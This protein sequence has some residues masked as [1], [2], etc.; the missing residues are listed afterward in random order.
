MGID[1]SSKLIFGWEIKYIKVVK[2]LRDLNIGSC[3][4]DKYQCFCGKCCWDMSKLPEG[5]HIIKSSPY[6][7]SNPEYC[8]YHL[9]LI[10]D[11]YTSF[12]TVEKIM[13]N[14][15]LVDNLRQLAIKLGAENSEPMFKSVMNVD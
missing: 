7:D 12:G 15:E 6:Y 2:Y 3:G 10:R 5:C 1:Y 14:T 9:S 8:E 13:K 4:G 11:Q